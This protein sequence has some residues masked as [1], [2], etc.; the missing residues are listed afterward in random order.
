M[1]QRSATPGPGF[2][3]PRS[4][5]T[6]QWQLDFTQVLVRRLVSSPN[7]RIATLLTLASQRDML[8][9]LAKQLWDTPGAITVLL[10]EILSVYPFVVTTFSSPTVSQPILSVAQESRACH[11]ICLFQTL[12]ANKETQIPFVKGNFLLYLGPFIHSTVQ[13]RECEAF[14]LASLGVIGNLAKSNNKEVIDY[15]LKNDFIP[16]CL[17]VIK[18]GQEVT[19][20]LAA[21]ILQRLLAFPGGIADVKASKKK[22]SILLE[23]LNIAVNDLIR[24]YSTRIARNIVIAYEALLGDADCCRVAAVLLSEK[25]FE[26]TPPKGSDQSFVQ[27]IT[28]LKSLKSEL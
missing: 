4:P 23:V 15:L 22:L 5:P 7:E 26:L 3:R 17:R 10:S 6:T 9:D 27:F 11:A 19:K 20:S 12:A 1:I 28:H 24:T 25:N 16:R 8:T 13:T 2:N 21:F 18:F 14:R